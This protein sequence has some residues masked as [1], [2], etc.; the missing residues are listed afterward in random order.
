MHPRGL[1]EIGLKTY[2]KKE[3]EFASCRKND[4]RKFL[5]ESA[6]VATRRVRF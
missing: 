1:A 4:Y 6:N 2:G 5:R 3:S